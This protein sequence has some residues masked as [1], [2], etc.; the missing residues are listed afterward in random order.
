MTPKVSVHMLA[1][2]H[3]RFIAG[4]LD[5]ALAQE[6]DFDYEIVV[7]DDA[8]RDRTPD[9]IRDYA[10]KHPHRVR[11]ILR[12]KNVGVVTNCLDALRACQGEY[13]AFLE[14][15]DYWTSPHKLQKQV[16]FLD[17]HPEYTIITHPVDVIDGLTG[18]KLYTTVANPQPDGDL[19]DV[20]AYRYPMPTCGVLIRNVLQEIPTWFERMHNLDYA[21]QL[22]VARRGKVRFMSEV[23]GA[24]RKHPQGISESTAAAERVE[25]FIDLLQTANAELDYEYDRLFRRRLAAMYRSKTK[26]ELKRRRF[27]A[28]ARAAWDYARCRATA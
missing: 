2:N 3:E 1:Y 5:S 12:E 21:T 13:V 18:K 4:A 26:I 27:G 8:S 24:Y 23:M 14:G 17:A 15:D 11:P 19:A 28:A 7:S 22:M 20:I 25:R 9:I 16:A 6:T 10:A